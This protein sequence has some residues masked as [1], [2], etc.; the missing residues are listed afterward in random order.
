[1]NKAFYNKS[2]NYLS[3][4]KSTNKSIVLALILSYVS[5]VGPVV[6]L[7]TSG[8]VDPGSIPD[9]VEDFN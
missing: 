8:L 2:A 3:M 9:R 1:M 6:S 5:R 4:M 7:S